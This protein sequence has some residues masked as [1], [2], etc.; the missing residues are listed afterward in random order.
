[1]S[2]AGQ[3]ST[4]P[5][6]TLILRSQ[7]VGALAL[8]RSQAFKAAPGTTAS[9]SNCSGLVALS[10]QVTGPWRENLLPGHPAV[11]TVRLHRALSGTVPQDVPF[12][13]QSTLIATA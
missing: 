2:P 13:L 7:E 6:P 4:F 12:L 1:M 11:P 5:G 3:R 8:S 10:W 9:G